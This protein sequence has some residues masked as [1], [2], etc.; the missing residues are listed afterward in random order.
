MTKAEIEVPPTHTHPLSLYLYLYLSLSL[1]RSCRVLFALL[2]VAH[3]TSSFYIINKH[4]MI[5]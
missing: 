4:H 1:S 2:G 5:F 3:I